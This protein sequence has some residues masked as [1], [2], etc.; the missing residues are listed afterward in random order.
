MTFEGNYHIALKLMRYKSLVLAACAF[1][2][3]LTVSVGLFYTKSFRGLFINESQAADQ[4]RSQ[5]VKIAVFGLKNQRAIET[6]LMVGFLRAYNLNFEIFHVTDFHLLNQLWKNNQFDVLIGR[7]P[8]H[9]LDFDGYNGFDY[10]NLK[11]SLFCKTKAMKEILVPEEYYKLTR[12][13]VKKFDQLQNSDLVKVASPALTILD[14]T[15]NKPN[16]CVI[17]E[18]R[19]AKN[20]LFKKNKFRHI[21]AFEQ[22]YPMAWIFSDRA[23]NLENLSSIWYQKLNQDN[24]IIK[25]WDRAEASQ[26][27]LTLLEYRRFK[28]DIAELLPEWRSTF[29]KYGKEFDVP[30]LLIAAVAYQESKWNN[31]AVSYTGVKGMM[32]LTQ[33]TAKHVGVEDREDAEQSIRGGAY[34]LRHLYDK[35]PNNIT[36]FERWVFTLASYNIG[37]S[38][39]RDI[40]RLASE[41]NKN[42]Y[43]WTQLQKLLLLKTDKKYEKEF[44]FGLARGDE[45]VAFVRNVLS[46]YDYL[47]SHYR[48]GAE[49]TLADN[50]NSF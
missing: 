30:W 13:E 31:A 5:K 12:K 41:Q 22:S 38:H 26:F 45:T 25:Y 28:N 29:K 18:S 36:P 21:M 4:A 47:K 19:M 34:Y 50:T 48:T 17:A 6:D 44:Y 9:E 20:L 46:Y 10:D 1:F 2:I 11:L 27:N 3:S 49:I 43:S 40:R 35:T 39:M 14:E 37:H 16:I 23:G 32:Q 8:S 42:P 33:L 7:L 15:Q 24:D